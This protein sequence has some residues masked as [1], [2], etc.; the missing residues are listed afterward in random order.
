MLRLVFFQS[1]WIKSYEQLKNMKFTIWPIFENQCQL[2]AKSK[3]RTCCTGNLNKILYIFWEIIKNV[4]CELF[5][6]IGFSS[7]FKWI[8][9]FWNTV[10]SDELP[11]NRE[12]SIIHINVYP[13]LKVYSNDEY[14]H[15]KNQAKNANFLLDYL[16]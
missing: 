14:Y 1:S 8:S 15:W 4:M 5:V 3:F 13:V 10:F 2:W 12:R 7:I 16:R 11:I 9:I 6:F